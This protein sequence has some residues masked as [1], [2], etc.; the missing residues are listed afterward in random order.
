[1]LV[2]PSEFTEGKIILLSVSCVCLDLH[3]HSH[4]CRHLGP[5]AFV[6]HDYL[7]LWLSWQPTYW[8]KTNK[9]TNKTLLCPSHLYHH[10]LRMLCPLHYHR[11]AFVALVGQWYRVWSSQLCS[12]SHIQRNNGLCVCFTFSLRHHNA[13]S[14]PATSAAIFD[15]LVKLKS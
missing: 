13:W 6:L 12:F 9:N 14:R 1:M 3:T 4:R 15:T 7:I 10:F 5:D 8:T 11:Y 2:G